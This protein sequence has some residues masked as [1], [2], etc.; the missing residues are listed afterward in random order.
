MQKGREERWEERMRDMK[1]WCMQN[2]IDSYGERLGHRELAYMQ[3]VGGNLGRPLRAM[4]LH[5]MQESVNNVKSDMWGVRQAPRA[6]HITI[7]NCIF[8]HQSWILY[9]R[10]SMSIT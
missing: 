2:I 10:H 8:L 6:L 9:K 7:S 5:C 4:E 3:N 1:L